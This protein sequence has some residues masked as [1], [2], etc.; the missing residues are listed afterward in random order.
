MQ[1]A[2]DRQK[3]GRTDRQVDEKVD[4]QKETERKRNRQTQMQA[5]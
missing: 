4:I 3:R 5:D 2:T 1:I